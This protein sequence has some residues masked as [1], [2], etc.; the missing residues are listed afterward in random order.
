MNKSFYF[1]DFTTIAVLS[2][3]QKYIKEHFWTKENYCI[4]GHFCMGRNSFLLF[5]LNHC[6]HYPL[7]GNS[8]F[9]FFFNVLF[10]LTIVLTFCPQSVFHWFYFLFLLLLLPLTLNLGPFFIYLFFYFHAKLSIVE[11]CLLG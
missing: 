11:K 8:F 4:K 2:R 3:C 1:L 9:F 10:F 7:V 6:Y 5:F